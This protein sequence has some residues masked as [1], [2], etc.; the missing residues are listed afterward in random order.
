[1]NELEKIGKCLEEAAEEPKKKKFQGEENRRIFL[2]VNKRKRNEREVIVNTQ[3]GCMSRGGKCQIGKNKSLRV[4]TQRSLLGQDGNNE[5]NQKT[6]RAEVNSVA[7][8]STTAT[9][10]S[11]SGGGRSGRSGVGSRGLRVRVGVRVGSSR[12]KQ[13]GGSPAR[14]WR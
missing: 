6:S 10:G 13:R 11:G 1:M 9:A 2:S 14:A 8:S 4:C 7:V 12:G 5:G 3:R